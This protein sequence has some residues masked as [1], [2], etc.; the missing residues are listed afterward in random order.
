M[1]KL[2]VTLPSWGR[3]NLT[4]RMLNCICMQTFSDFEIFFLGDNC[5]AF[6]KILKSADFMYFQK[7]LGNRL[8][9]FN[10]K[11]RDGTSSQAINYSMQK[12]S[13]DWFLFLSNDDM[14]LNNHFENYVTISENKQTDICLFNSFVD[15]GN[16]ILKTR[17]AKVEL[18]KCGHSELC[19]SK[20]TYK[21]APLH[22][23]NYGHDFE[24]LINC[25]NMGFSYSLANNNPTYI[26]NSDLTRERSWG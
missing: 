5:Q 4:K 18:E 10:F 8:N 26:V 7:V 12:G 19:V 24:F 11:D 2:T 20:K 13:G 21:N 22:S 15:Y 23:R 25:I 16:G 1:P 14:I 6:D 3:E 9:F 17:T